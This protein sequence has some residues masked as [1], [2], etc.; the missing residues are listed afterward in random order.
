MSC[1]CEKLVAE[2]GDLSGTQ[3]KGNFRRWKP[4]PSNDSEDVT[5][6]TSVCVCVYVKD[7]HALYR[8]AIHSVINPRPIYS[9]IHTRDNILK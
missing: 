2:A 6:D 1:R 9:H 8:S 7:S 5:L 4:L 3:R